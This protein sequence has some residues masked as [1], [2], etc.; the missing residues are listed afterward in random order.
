EREQILAYSKLVAG[1]VSGVAGGDVNAAANAAAVAVEK[2]SLNFIQE[3]LLSGDYNKC[4]SSGGSDSYCGN[5][6]PLGIPHFIAAEVAL[7]QGSF[8]GKSTRIIINT[9]TGEVFMS[10]SGGTNNSRG[11][12]KLGA[13]LNFG[14]VINLSP[15]ERA[16]LG[17]EINN[18]LKGVSIGGKGCLYGGCLGFS[19]TTGNSPKKFTME[20]GIGSGISVGGE[21]VGKIGEIK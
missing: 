10:L 19:S 4:R 20:V 12:G 15:T 16:K 6:K 5:Y 1:T 13:S 21:F 18:T 8:V 11:S 14:W 3:G 2:N 7:P 17:S 9:R